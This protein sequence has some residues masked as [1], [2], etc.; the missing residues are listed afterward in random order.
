MLPP[1][2][3]RPRRGAGAAASARVR[4]GARVALLLAVALAGCGERRPAPPPN[5][6]LV[7][8]D[9]LG[10][11]DL[12]FMG[13]RHARTPNLDRLAAEGAVFENAYATA[14]LCR[15]SLRSLLTGLH[16]LQWTARLRELEAQGVRRPP[17]Q[18]IEAF[19]TLPT[20]LRA[21]GYASFQGGKFWEGTYALAGF[22]A[23]TQLHG[24]GVNDSRDG[25]AFGRETLEPVT[26]FLD[27]HAGRPFF[28]WFAPML[29]HTPHDAPEEQLRL[30]RGRGLSGA[31]VGYYAN[32]TR[33]DAVVGELRAELERRGLL[34]RTLLVFVS[35]NGWDQPPD[36]ER[37]HPSF[38]GPRG[39][40][41]LY[42][43]GFR[44][45]IALRWPGHVPAGV[46]R[47]ELVSTVDLFPTFLDYAGVPA[48]AGLPGQS[49]RPLLEGRD[50]FSRESVVEGM[51]GARGGA[52]VEPDE[53]RRETGW[54]LRRDH[55]HYI[56]YEG[57]GEELYDVAA[58]PREEFDLAREQPAVA[59]R[60]RSEIQ[61]WRRSALASFAE[62]GVPVTPRPPSPSAKP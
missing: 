7:I 59:R 11:P 6:A 4:R 3:H 48:P 60:L 28:L 32:V 41:T 40:R 53:P 34:E 12:G 31:A 30:Y 55:W 1:M 21:R 8:A 36:A 17:A 14:S 9:D 39:K 51:S 57:D 10:Y 49:L 5:I 37:T 47:D 29:P 44:T 16:P 2:L 46:V 15:P 61:A 52:G 45:P 42:D 33:F 20:L 22:D 19:T 27:A 23:G 62:P 56:W 43:L 13:S 24:D 25:T 18:A 54:F 58:D 26:A 50:G 35:D 38:D